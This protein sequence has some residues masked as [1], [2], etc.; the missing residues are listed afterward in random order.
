M[1]KDNLF[2]PPEIFKKIQEASKADN[3]EMYQVFNMG[4]RME[5]YTEKD[6]AEKVVSLAS[7][8]N[9]DAQIIGR[10]EASEKKSLLIK[11]EDGELEF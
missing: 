7:E 10:V 3:R 11:T 2:A 5:I 8:F 4:C 6:F 9:I 1:I